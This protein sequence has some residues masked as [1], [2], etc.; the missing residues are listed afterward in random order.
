M[1]ASRTA[2]SSGCRATSRVARPA[3]ACPFRRFSTV[4]EA[5]VCGSLIA[6]SAADGGT[7]VIDRPT[8]DS[9]LETTSKT[10]KKR[11]PTY[12]VMLHNDSHN[13]REHVVSVLVRVVTG[14][15]ANRAMELMEEAHESGVA[16]IIACPQDEAEQYCEQLRLNGLTASIEH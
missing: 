4:V 8:T 14:M 6:M 7:G 16:L 3:C 13:R 10:I 2:S 12:K 15:V 9:S 5:P 11:P 1:I